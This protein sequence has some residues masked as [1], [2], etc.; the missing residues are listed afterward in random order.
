MHPI[1]ASR[2]RL[3]LYMI[4]WVPVTGVVTLILRRGPEV[5]GLRWTEALIIAAPMC[6]MYAFVC[7]ST[8]YVCRA[9][10][11]EDK[12]AGRIFIT[13]G[14]ASVLSSLIW[15]GTGLA[16]TLIVEPWTDNPLLSDR[17]YAQFLPLFLNGALLFLLAAS[18]HY[19][20]IAFDQ[21]RQVE[22]RALEMQILAREAELKVLRA[23]IDPHFLFNSLN[24]I[25]ALSMVDPA[26]SR[27]MCILLADFLRTSLVLGG[28][29]QISMD[30]ELHLTDNFLDI[31]KVRYGR[32]LNVERNIDVDCRRCMVPPLLLQPLV[33]NAVRHG[34]A[35]CIE[36]GTVRIDV[37]RTASELDIT[38]ENPVELDRISNNGT[39]VG[40]K[41]VRERLENLFSN[42]AR[43]EAYQQ[44]GK[45]VVQL[46]LPCIEFGEKS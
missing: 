14:T 3:A 30:E 33:E 5:P 9:V 2:E 29:S 8:W 15:F 17:Y 34:I 35:R 22:K 13:L 1:L 11:L 38:M 19:L 41:N 27:R 18:A 45:Y 12:K 44:D 28:K 4:T 43:I 20:L 23:Q 40:L 10:P 25:S 31:E 6:L 24:S 21:S 42:Q 16:W 32:R 7:L 36:G 46:R 26:G 39:G 37:R